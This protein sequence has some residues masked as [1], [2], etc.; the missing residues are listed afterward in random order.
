MWMLSNFEIRKLFYLIVHIYNAPTLLPRHN[1]VLPLIVLRNA[2]AALNVLLGN[3]PDKPFS[4]L[5]NC[6]NQTNLQKKL[7]RARQ[8]LSHLLNCPNH[9]T[10]TGVNNWMFPICWIFCSVTRAKFKLLYL[11]RKLGIFQL[12]NYASSGNCCS[13]LVRF[14][15]T[16]L[17][18]II[19]DRTSFNI[20]PKCRSFSYSNLAI[21]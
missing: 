6:P 10:H 9:T 7:E 12:K 2:R 14:G 5:L 19:L 11:S 15:Y 13:E 3:G 18:C 4:K 20:S 17:Y 16:R 1:A 21:V 8:A